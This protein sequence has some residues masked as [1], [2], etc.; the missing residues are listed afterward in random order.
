M[1]DVVIPDVVTGV[2]ARAAYK[3]RA[4][5]VIRIFCELWER[6]Q[7][8]IWDSTLLPDAASIEGR[9]EMEDQPQGKRRR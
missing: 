6:H 7:R 9:D 8:N 3:Q 4:W 5:H 1:P 2:G